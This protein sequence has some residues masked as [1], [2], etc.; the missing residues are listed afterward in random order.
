[1]KDAFKNELNIGDHII[2][3]YQHY[4]GRWDS[5]HKG[6]VIGFTECFVKIKLD[7]DDN[8]NFWAKSFIKVNGKYTWVN[9]PYILRQPHKII[10]MN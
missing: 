6:T 10:K 2:Y 7:S 9:K 4:D 8:D 5:F 1:M 3:M